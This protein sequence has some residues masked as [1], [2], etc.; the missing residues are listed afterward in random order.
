MRALSREVSVLKTIATQQ[1]GVKELA[2]TILQEL[3]NK[4]DPDKKFWL[5]AEKAY[6]LIQKKRMEGVN[7]QILKKEIAQLSLSGNFNLYK[8]SD[9]FSGK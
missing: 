7:K 2:D 6:Q 3:Q 4:Q 9:G 8:Y 1:E 5:L